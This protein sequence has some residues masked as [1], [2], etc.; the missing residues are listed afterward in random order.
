MAY[1]S[2]ASERATGQRNGKCAEEPLG[3]CVVVSN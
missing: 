1:L 2:I 3:A